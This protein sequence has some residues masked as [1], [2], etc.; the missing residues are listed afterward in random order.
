MVAELGNTKKNLSQASF[1]VR[2]AIDLGAQLIVLPEFFTSAVA[3]N[4][5]MLDC[6]QP[7]DGPAMRLLQELAREGQAM[8]GGSYLAQRGEHVYNT[9]VVSTPDGRT[10]MHDKDQPTMWENCYYTGGSDP[11]LLTTPLGR[12]G[13][14]LCWE[15]IRSRTAR[16]LL[17]QVDMVIGGSCWWTGP[18]DAILRN[19]EAHLQN[20]EL[21]H[22]TPSRMA[23]ILGVPV[24]HASHAGQCHGFSPP[25]QS[26]P[27]KSHF[28][29]ETQ[30]VDGH[31]KI[32]Q[33][34]TYEDGEGVITADITPG[35]G[36]AAKEAI[37]DSF[38]IP[39]L[40]ESSLRLWQELNRFG[41]GYYQNTTL[42]LLHTRKPA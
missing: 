31:G 12:M 34:M 35:A 33:C 16:R 24:V 41:E 27:F 42:P 2:Q 38:W 6:I 28:L 26:R 1:L 14:A 17:D 11:G 10:L 18:E 36:Q 8:V 39:D 19:P 32:L 37:P 7:L 20:I 21:L 40:P 25:D 30:I 23:R 3:F 15:F 4:T 22:D 13:A 5:C 9:L 29:G